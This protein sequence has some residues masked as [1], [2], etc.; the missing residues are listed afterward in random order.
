MRGETDSGECGFSGEGRGPQNLGSLEPSRIIP[1]LR[2]APEPV[3]L[4]CGYS[5]LPQR[6][7]VGTKG[8]SFVAT[9]RVTAKGPALR[10]GAVQGADAILL[11][12]AAT[13]RDTA[14]PTDRMPGTG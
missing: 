13:W 11:H 1:F 14:G 8:G 12:E 7:R 3:S 2:T 9:P 10:R 4:A 5:G 6:E